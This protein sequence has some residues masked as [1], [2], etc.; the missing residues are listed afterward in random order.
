MSDSC[1]CSAEAGAGTCELRVL[2][3]GA[4]VCPTNGKSGKRVDAEIVK[5]M[6]AL[7]LTEI[8]NTQYYFCREVDC[9]TVYYSADGT[10][11]FAESDLRERVY[12]KHMNEGDVFVCYCFRHTPASIRDELRET[13]KSSVIESINDG[14]RSGKCACDI[15]NPQG[16]CCLGN[17]NK[18]VKSIQVVQ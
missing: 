17:V 6:L 10:Q 16:S 13:G 4:V 3:R 11:T 7:P 18:L 8:R 15:R 5:A 14:I 12:Q 1:Q 9:Q 2:P